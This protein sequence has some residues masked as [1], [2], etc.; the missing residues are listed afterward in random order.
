MSDQDMR[1]VQEKLRKIIAP[2]RAALMIVDMQND[3]VSPKGK[4]AEFGFYL[5]SV[6]ET[7]QPI[8][9]L[10]QTARALHYPV[11]HTSMI[12]DIHQNPLSWYAFWGEP[13]VTLPGSWGAAHIDEL[14]P[15]NGE[16]IIT[17]YTYSA[18]EGTN[19]HTI[20]R[21][22]GI[23]TVMLTGT[24][25]NICAGDTL[26]QAFALGYH[27]VAVSD[28]LASFSRIGAEHSA[29]LHQMGL[30]I[31]ANHF[32]AVVTSRQ[33]IAMMQPPP[34]LSKSEA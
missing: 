26:H 10:L 23:Q 8:K 21:R 28:C 22:K 5:E 33:L 3:F 31:V 25:L 17:K 20:L 19:L 14:Q 12:N 32:G 2:D 34:G 24:D 6:R 13:V 9:A 18:F 16:L 15:Q 11:L 30:Y 1:A 4:M 7:I 27:V 29:Q